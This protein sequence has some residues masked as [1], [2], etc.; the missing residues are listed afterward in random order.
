M[1]S[2]VPP[3]GPDREVPDREVANREVPNREVTVLL[4]AASAGDAQA[5][6]ELIARLYEELRRIAGRLQARMGARDHTLQPTAVVHE[7]FLKLVGAADAS[8]EGRR[9]FL[10]AA[11]RA[12]RQVLLNYARDRRAEKRG[13]GRVELRI[14]THDLVAKCPEIEALELEEALQRLEQIDAR[15]ARVVELRYYGGLSVEETADALQVSATTVKN[16]W[17]MARAE[18]ARMLQGRGGSADRD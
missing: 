2:P 18:L 4:H 1:N 16:E 8:Y 5:R 17:R 11:A 6:E 12:M 3:P 15:Q 7:A 10:C 14:S 13:G 9:H